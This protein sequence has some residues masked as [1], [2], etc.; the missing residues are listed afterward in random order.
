MADIV[1]SPGGAA[2]SDAPGGLLTGPVV[3]PMDVVPFPMLVADSAGRALASNQ[4]W[5]DLSGLGGDGSMGYGWL[6][7]LRP[8]DRLAL[9]SQVERVAAGDPDLRADYVW[10][11]GGG[12]RATW[13]LASHQRAGERVVGIGVGWVRGGAGALGAS[14]GAGSV[15][16]GAGAGVVVGAGAAGA[17]VAAAAGDPDPVRAELP[18]LLA[19]VRAL[20]ATLDRLIEHIVLLET[21]SV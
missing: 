15:A 1:G 21:A 2:P 19:S 7:V 9:R 12:G 8:E 16:A 3:V 17:G 13:W 4:R 14:D 18:A 5:R 11:P 6:S 10:L 20:L